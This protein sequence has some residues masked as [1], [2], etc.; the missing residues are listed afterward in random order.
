MKNRESRQRERISN[1]TPKE[2]T[3]RSLIFFN[4]SIVKRNPFEG[5]KIAV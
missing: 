3:V 2:Q 1:L 5:H 4:I